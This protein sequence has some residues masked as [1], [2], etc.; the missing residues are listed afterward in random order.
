MDNNNPTQNYNPLNRATSFYDFSTSDNEG[1]P[2]P[3]VSMPIPEPTDED[4]NGTATQ[5]SGGAMTGA[6]AS[7]NGVASSGVNPLNRATSFYDFSSLDNGEHENKY[8]IAVPPVKEPTTS[9]TTTTGNG[10]TSGGAD[11]SNTKAAPNGATAET[12]DDPYSQEVVKNYED[13]ARIIRE[14]MN[15]VPEETKE[16]REA[17]ERREK[18]TSWLA[19]LADGLGSY[20]TTFAYARGEKPMDMPKMSKRAEELYEKQKAEREKNRDLRMNYAINIANLGNEKVK[21]LREIAAQR[22]AQRLA[23]A[24]ND[25]EDEQQ[26][27]ERAL[28]PGIQREQEGKATKAEQEAITAKEEAKNAPELFK[29]KVTTEKARGVAQVAAANAHNAAAENSR[30]GAVAHKAAATK[31]YAEANK[32]NKE[33]QQGYPW[34]EP[35]GTKH[36]AK[37]EEE[38]RYRQEQSGT[39]IKKVNGEQTNKTSTTPIVYH[40]QVT[41]NKTSTTR[42]TKSRYIPMKPENRTPPSRRNKNKNNTPPSRR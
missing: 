14:R 2:T 4:N 7:T 17:R 30:A 6:P 37:T 10:A 40:G 16:E 5:T 20:H 23:R 33:A 42:Q 24:K 13:M 15:E 38:A 19:R 28:Q 8:G 18:Q 12:D 36:L 32:T 41:G 3:G 35:N 1:Q 22:E 29:A 26:G 27:W 25:R 31:S 39:P 9:G 21:A 34:W 11:T